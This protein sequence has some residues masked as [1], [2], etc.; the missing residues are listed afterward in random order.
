MSMWAYVH[1]RPEESIASP[2]LDLQAVVS[3]QVITVRTEFQS[4][5]SAVSTRI[6]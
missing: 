2:L 5:A 4:S 6:S 3:H 1:M